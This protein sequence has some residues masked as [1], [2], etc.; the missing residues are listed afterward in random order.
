MST[1]FEVIRK[2]LL[3]T[4]D[5]Y[6]RLQ[7]DHSLYGKKIEHLASKGFL[8]EEERVKEKTLKKLK[9]HAKDQMQNLEQEKMGN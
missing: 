7:A 9:L 6:R 5:Q 8:N 4:S 3:A 1:R 2:Q